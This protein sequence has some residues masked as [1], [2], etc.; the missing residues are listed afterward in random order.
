[1]TCGQC[2]KC[3]EGQTVTLYPGWIV[4]VTATRMVLCE[5]CGCKRC[6]HATDCKLACTNSNKPGQ[7]GSVYA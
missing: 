3:L 6:P 5:T 1:M 4:P 7:P 2:R